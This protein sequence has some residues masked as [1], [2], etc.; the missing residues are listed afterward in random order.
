MFCSAAH[1]TTLVLN[2]NCQNLTG[3]AAISVGFNID[4]SPLLPFLIF[5]D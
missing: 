5:E 3:T 4:V 2:I 1:N